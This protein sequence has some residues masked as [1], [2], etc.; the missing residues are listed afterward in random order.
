V[1]STQVL[2]GGVGVSRGPSV[3]GAR[4]GRVVQADD[5]AFRDHQGTC[6]PIPLLGH[7]RLRLERAWPDSAIHWQGV[8]RPVVIGRTSSRS[9]WIGWAQR[10]QRPG[11]ALLEPP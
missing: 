3:G 1:D 7:A 2:A 9:Q 5:D 4:G 6:H 8:Q 10:S 11:R